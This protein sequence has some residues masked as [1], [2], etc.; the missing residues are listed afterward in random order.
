[1]ISIWE[2]IAYILPTKIILAWCFF[3]FGSLIELV[4]VTLPL[5]KDCIQIASFI[6]AIILSIL[7]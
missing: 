4:E 5:I 6:I 3:A 1:M 7:T 2:K